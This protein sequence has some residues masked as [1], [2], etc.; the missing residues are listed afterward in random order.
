MLR[1][2]SLLKIGAVNMFNKNKL[3]TCSAAIICILAANTPVFA[4][5]DIK[6]TVQNTEDSPINVSD[7]FSELNGNLRYASTDSSIVRKD[8]VGRLDYT[9]TGQKVIKVARFHWDLLDGFG[10]IVDS[11]DLVDEDGVGVEEVKTHEWNQL[12]NE[13]VSSAIVYVSEVLFDDGSSWSAKAANASVSYE[14][15]TRLLER[16]RLLEL[17]KEKGTDELIR[18]LSE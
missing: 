16:Q 12:V 6:V 10:K 7:S 14:E 5:I 18:A 8:W 9:N 11:V 17:Y 1:G 15:R 3:K 2:V 13:G 4:G